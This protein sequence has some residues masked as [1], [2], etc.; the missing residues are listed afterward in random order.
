M[1][2]LITPFR[3]GQVDEGKLRELVQYHLAGGTNGLV[4][5][6]TTGEA[7]T[8]SDEE[9]DRVIRVVVETVAGRIPVIAGT[10]TNSTAKTIKY[11]R[12]AK[13]AG[14]DAALIVTPYYNKPTPEGLY[15]HYEAIAQATDLPII[16]YNVPSR[17]SVNMLPETV[18]RLARIDAIVGIKEASGNMDQVSQI[19]QSCPSD[20]AVLSGDDS[21]TLPMLALGGAGVIS[22]VA[23][24]APTAMSELVAAFHRDDVA[25]A[26][27]LHYGLFDLCRAM[28]IETNPIPVK[29]A[30]GLLG[31]CLDELRLPLC[32]MSEGNRRKLADVVNACRFVQP[33]P[34]PLS[35]NA[36]QKAEERQ[37]WFPSPAA[38]DKAQERRR[39]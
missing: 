16:L 25:R 39:G 4:P 6:G 18:A 8:L 10:G 19:V 23:N 21:L 30:A 33:A 12:A 26:R 11:T 17:T 34:L 38:Q 7:V 27:E 31:L 29:T 37:S 35:R 15:R 3:D 32:P 20:F 9:Q 36:G 1:V 14:A 22:V 2:A 24:I 5:C 28:F 13:Q